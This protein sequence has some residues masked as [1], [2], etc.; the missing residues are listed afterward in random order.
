MLMKSGSFEMAG[1]SP[2]IPEQTGRN[3]FARIMLRLEAYSE[4]RRQRSALMAL[5]DYMLKDIG[6]S[7]AEAERIA[8]EPFDWH[9]I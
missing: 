1:R 6:L 5:D 8:A 2:A 7:R 3:I 4:F 9:K